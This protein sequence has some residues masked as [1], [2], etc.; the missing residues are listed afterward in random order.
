MT[1][2]KRVRKRQL[3]AV[4]CNQGLGGI[5]ATATDKA[6]AKLRA[7][8]HVTGNQRIDF[9]A[10]WNENARKRH[11]RLVKISV[12]VPEYLSTPYPGW[13]N[14]PPAD[15]R[16]EWD[17]GFL[18]AEQCKNRSSVFQQGRRLCKSH[19]AKAQRDGECN[20]ITASLISGA[21]SGGW[22]E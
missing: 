15:Q 19:L 10:W 16:C 22:H 12:E 2:S 14:Y 7:V 8:I 20:F 5:V 18:T 13:N 17:T 3:W 11:W 4:F 9:E 21:T 6:N 1:K